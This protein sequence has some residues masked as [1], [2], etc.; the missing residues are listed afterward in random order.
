MAQ[1]ISQMEIEEIKKWCNSRKIDYEKSP[2]D[3]QIEW[4]IEKVHGYLRTHPEDKVHIRR[5]HY[6]LGS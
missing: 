3:R 5:L 1:N 2:L 6:W 4:A